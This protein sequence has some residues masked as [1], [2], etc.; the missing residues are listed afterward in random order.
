MHHV[1][2]ECH[3][4][5]AS[6]KQ[7][8]AAFKEPYIVN[9]WVLKGKQRFH[10]FPPTDQRANV[11][12]RSNY[13]M[14]LLQKRMTDFNA[15]KLTFSIICFCGYLTNILITLLG[16]GTGDGWW[17]PYFQPRSCLA[18]P[19]VSLYLNV[20]EKSKAM[21]NEMDNPETQATVKH[22]SKENENHTHNKN[23]RENTKKMSNTDP[24]SPG[25]PMCSRWV[26]HFSN[27]TP[28]ATHSQVR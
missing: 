13:H 25:E 1:F 4:P 14:V 5:W 18:R 23:K 9:G 28:A 2:G 12:E 27:K 16:M 17:L 10:A 15:I 7:L 19:H 22:R 3:A 11:W 26:S 21:N 24:K 8:A 6:M 20:R